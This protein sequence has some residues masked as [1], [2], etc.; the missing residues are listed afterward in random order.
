MSDVL[1]KAAV[2]SHQGGD[3][4]EAARLYG[5][6]LTADPRHF[7]A[8][9]LLGFVRFQ[10][11]A[12]DQAEKLIADA[13]KINPRS[14]DAFYNRGCALQRL[15]RASE[16]VSCFDSAIRLKP[17]YDEAWTNRGVVLLALRDYAGAL[18]SFDRALSLKPRDREA[19][20]NRAGALFELKRFGD[21]AEAYGRLLDVAPDFPYA[22]G[23]RVLCRAYACDWRDVEQERAR[24]FAELSRNK[25]VLQAHA[26][27]LLLDDPELQLQCARNWV[28]ERYPPAKEPLW[29]GEHYRHDKIRLAYLS[30][31][32][33]A[34]AT[35]YL[36]AGVIEQHDKAKFETSAISFGPDDKSEMR[37]R[38]ERGVD[39]FIEARAKSDREIAELIRAMEID[40]AV[41]LK[42]HTQEGR[43]GVLA[44]RP[45]PVQVN[46]LGHPGTM[47]AP[48][49]DYF[50]A[51]EVVIP[52]E[53]RAHYQEQVVYLPGSYQA[54]DSRRAIASRTPSRAEEGLPEEGFVFCSFNSCYKITPE[55]FG[56][57]M[58]L[59][60]DVPESCLWLLEDNADAVRN[61]KREAEARGQDPARLIFA[62]RRPL[63][64]HLARKKLAD[65]FLDTLPCNAHTTASDALW[66]GVPVLTFKGSTFAGRVAASLLSA[67]GLDELVTCS[68]EEYEAL[69][70][71]IAGDPHMLSDLK[72]KLL[73]NRSTYP[74]FDTIKTT[75][76]LEAAFTTMVERYRN[77]VTSASFSAGNAA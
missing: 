38:L 57:W 77:G 36:I 73:R 35:A 76:N 65:L 71:R 8:L 39:R 37:A 10:Q 67:V 49:I 46:Y 27:T 64:Q 43:P 22:L 12:F 53:S 5:A 7:Q 58:R 11:G 50:V 14:P 45:A 24:L 40:I 72:T 41:D 42:G 30:A 16:A 68:R 56:L 19:L 75:R 34:H 55:I 4:A 15:Q 69:A 17:D 33:H 9:Y 52:P 62:P 66:A 70:R 60:R 28:A 48:Y 32:F 25:P 44:F 2:R 63:E 21:A 20:S 59:L 54:N 13:L 3:L 1:L 51:D 29:R 47:G 6:I 26:A 61:L 74:L 18:A 23:T 31:D